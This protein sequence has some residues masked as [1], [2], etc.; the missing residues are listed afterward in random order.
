MALRIDNVITSG[1]FSLDGED[2]EVDKNIWLV[3]D[4]DEVIVVDAAHDH[5]PIVAGVDLT[6]ITKSVGPG[7]HAGDRIG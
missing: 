3:G 7:A 6:A 1:I 4:D 5:R 2:F